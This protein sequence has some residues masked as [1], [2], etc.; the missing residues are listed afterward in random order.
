MRSVTIV[1]GRATRMSAGAA[2]EGIGPG[3]AAVARPSIL[4]WTGLLAGAALLMVFPQLAPW[5]LRPFYQP[6]SGFPAE[7]DA[8]SPPIPALVI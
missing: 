5:A 7:L 4:I 6:G 2:R 8:T 1:E 3:R